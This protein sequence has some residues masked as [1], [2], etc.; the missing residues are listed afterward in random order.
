MLRYE[1]I[2]SL[3]SRKPIAHSSPVE[4]CLQ[5]VRKAEFHWASKAVSSKGRFKVQGM[6]W[7]GS[8][9]AGM[10]GCKKTQLLILSAESG[11][12][13]FSFLPPSQTISAMAGR[14]ET[15]KGS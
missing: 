7:L 13:F 5:Q 4:S 3:Q 10:P 8:Q 11:L 6:F 14:Q 9:E 15:E 12:G 2:C 1:R